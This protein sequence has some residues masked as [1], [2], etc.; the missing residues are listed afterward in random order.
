MA[1]APM[2]EIEVLLGDSYYNL[3]EVTMLERASAE[4]ETLV[5]MKKDLEVL[6][7]H[8]EKQQSKDDPEY[9][10]TVFH[11]FRLLSK[12]LAALKEGQPL[13]IIN[14]PPPPPAS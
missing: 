9:E 6:V 2:R 13:P 5:K 1:R 4:R 11:Y 3:R 7:K 8:L 10:Q 14:P 12:W